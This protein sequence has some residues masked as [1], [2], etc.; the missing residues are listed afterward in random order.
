MAKEKKEVEEDKNDWKL[1]DGSEGPFKASYCRAKYNP[2]RYGKCG[3]HDYT[4]ELLFDDGNGTDGKVPMSFYMDWGST[5]PTVSDI[6]DFL[7]TKIVAVGISDEAK[8]VSRNATN[9]NWE[10][11]FHVRHCKSL[12][13]TFAALIGPDMFGAIATPPPPVQPK[14]S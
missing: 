7:V 9:S 2:Y 1:A 6:I 8:N 14:E 4:V 5:P 3:A 10:R 11:W 12:T 13:A